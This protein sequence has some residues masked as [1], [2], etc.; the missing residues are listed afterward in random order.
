MRSAIMNCFRETSCP[1]RLDD[2][3]NVWMRAGQRGSGELMTSCGNTL[4]VAANTAVAIAACTGLSLK[5]VC[6]TVAKVRYEVGSMGGTP[7]IREIEVTRFCQL[8]NGD[9]T[10]LVTT[11]E[12]ARTIMNN[13][14]EALTL[15]RKA[16]RSG[17][18]GADG[19]CQ[20]GQFQIFSLR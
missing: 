19:G 9:D 16:I 2:D 4:L 15:Q 12:W 18:S 5:E 20:R 3:G 10:F 14:E 6:E 1:I 7:A 11:S 13:I 17:S 8:S